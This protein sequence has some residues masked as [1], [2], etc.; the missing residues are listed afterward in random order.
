MYAARPA[1][2]SLTR[3]DRLDDKYFTQTL[4]P[5]YLEQHPNETEEWDVVYDARGH[6][7]E[8]HTEHS[9][10][11]GTLA[12]RQYL[13]ERPEI[14]PPAALDPGSMA[15]TIGPANRYST[16]LF[17]E[18]EGFD[19][20]LSAAR[21]AERF[22]IAIMSTKGM[23]VTAAR[24]LLDRLASAIERVVVLHDFDLSGFSIFGTLSADT[25][26][27]RFENDV[28]FVDLGLRLEDV[29]ELELQSEPIAPFERRMGEARVD[30]GE[31]WRYASGNRVPA[32]TTCR[33]E[34]HDG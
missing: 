27:Y 13:G 34:R 11:L 6:Y 8:P 28:P 30:V 19:P 2:L 3:R 7:V 26:R 18:K 9:V 17:I 23:S 22:D 33:V 32:V 10:A 25:R 12:V 4:L 14:N 21:I 16:V 31:V 24:L 1:I 20:L 5:D 15:V 29:E